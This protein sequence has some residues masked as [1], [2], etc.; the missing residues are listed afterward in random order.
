MSHAVD[1]PR[2]VRVTC[3]QPRPVSSRSDGWFL[4]HVNNIQ[5]DIL[6]F[7]VR[8]TVLSVIPT[9]GRGPGCYFRLSRHYLNC[10][11]SKSLKR[12]RKQPS[13]NNGCSDAWTVTWVQKKELFRQRKET[14][15]FK[16]NL[17]QHGVFFSKYYLTQFNTRVL[18]KGQSQRFYRILFGDQRFKSC[19]LEENCL[20]GADVCCNVSEAPKKIGSAIGVLS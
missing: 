8:F 3:Q 15:K 11:Y 6:H 10:E 18:N 16:L 4:K 12:K 2:F 7:T 5:T 19:F 20:Y 9:Y 14:G 17:H 1:V 13:S